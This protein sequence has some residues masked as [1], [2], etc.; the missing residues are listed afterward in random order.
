[1]IILFIY[2]TVCV[3][4][5][6][7]ASVCVYLEK[8]ASLVDL[9]NVLVVKDAAAPLQL[10]LALSGS[11]RNDGLIQAADRKEKVK[12]ERTGLE[13]SIN[14]CELRQL[15]LWQRIDVSDLPGHSHGV[16]INN[17]KMLLPKEQKTF[18][19]VQTLNPSTTVHV[20]DLDHRWQTHKHTVN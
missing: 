5:C 1:M 20:L 8:V 18:T 6:F 16:A 10:T 11:S 13:V 4:V 12:I 17:V 19:G 2:K 9:F 14:W 7:C 3:C 15:L